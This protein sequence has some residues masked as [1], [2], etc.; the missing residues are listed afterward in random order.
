MRSVGLLI[1]GL[2]W[3][4]GC[5]SK[6]DHLRA[7]PQLPPRA[8]E[9]VGEIQKIDVYDIPALA[10]DVG[11]SMS[12]VPRPRTLVREAV[13]SSIQLHKLHTELW[14]SVGMPPETTWS[15][16]EQFVISW[17]GISHVKPKSGVMVS[18][19]KADISREFRIERGL[20]PLT[21]EIF[22][23]LLHEDGT[24]LTEQHE[25]QQ[26]ILS[27]MVEFLSE[28]PRQSARASL[29]AQNISSQQ[30][31]RL[32]PGTPPRLMIYLGFQ[33]TWSVMERVLVSLPWEVVDRNRSERSFDIK[34][35]GTE[36]FLRADTA[37]VEF[38]LQ[39]EQRRTG[40]EVLVGSDDPELTDEVLQTVYRS[41]N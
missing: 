11:S 20:Q 15:A 33:R 37:A 32:L 26:Q 41:L 6:D 16:V 22:L 27:E 24:E 2:I 9:G 17:G 29:L 1:A 14:I 31:A 34:I 18:V 35:A 38:G 13:S 40:F 25:Q 19:A 12:E 8:P 4:G 23:R 28:L 7:Q 36:K 5:V 10:E 30:K 3:L 39:L 21:S